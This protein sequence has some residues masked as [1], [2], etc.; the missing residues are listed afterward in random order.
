L[1]DREIGEAIF[2]TEVAQLSKEKALVHNKR[3]WKDFKEALTERGT[4]TLMYTIANEAAEHF[5]KILKN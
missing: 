4:G 1:F 5:M 2:A 3:L